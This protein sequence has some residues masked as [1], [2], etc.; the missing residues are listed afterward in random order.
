ML[1][2]EFERAGGSDGH[3]RAA[4]T[5]HGRIGDSPAQRNRQRERRHPRREPRHR[6]DRRH[7]SGPRTPRRSRR[8]R[9]APARRSRSG[10]P[11]AS[12]AARGCCSRAQKW[13]IDNAERV[14][15]TIVSETGKT[16]EDAQLAEISYA[17]GAFGFWAKQG[18][19]YLEDESVKSS[20]VLVKGKKLMMRYRPLGLI[21]VIGP[22]NYPADELLRRLHPRADGRQQR[23]PQALRG[24]AADV[25]AAGRRAARVWPAG[26]RAADRDRPRRHGRCADRAG[27]HDHVHRLHAHR[28]EGRRSRRAGA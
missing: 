1:A 12:T 6:R 3:G 8:W 21:G 11:T 13:V 10:R 23:D 4:A 19:K 26:E 9:R 24:D 5:R 22:W 18:P 20:Q 7:G 15:E 27:R 25:V 17:A 16:Y 2:P 14:I 28:H